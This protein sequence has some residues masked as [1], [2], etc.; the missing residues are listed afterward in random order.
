MRASAARDLMPCREFVSAEERARQQYFL[1]P[2]NFVYGGVRLNL[3]GREPRGCVHPDDGQV[4]SELTKDLL[5]L[6]DLDSGRPVVRSVERSN[7]WH[8]RFASDTLPDLFVEYWDWVTLPET[9]WSQTGIVHGLYTNW[10]SGDH[11]PDGL[12]LARGPGLEANKMFEPIQVEDFGPT[13]GARLG[14]RLDDVDGKVVPW[15][16]ARG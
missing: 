10:R 11:R 9:V 12:L 6:V 15:L 3:M 5:L 13:I 16:A 7:R 2:N 1:E 8:R 4:I 14:V